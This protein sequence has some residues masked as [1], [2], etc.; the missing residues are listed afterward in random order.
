MPERIPAHEMLEHHTSSAVG[1]PTHHLCGSLCIDLASPGRLQGKLQAAV[2]VLQVLGLLVHV[3]QLDCSLEQ[4][5]K[6][7]HV[8]GSGLVCTNY[9]GVI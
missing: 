3:V 7:R 6:E 5:I 8:S 9:S 1:A 4:S 2:A